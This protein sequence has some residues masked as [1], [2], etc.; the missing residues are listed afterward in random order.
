MYIRFDNIN[1]AF[2]HLVRHFHRA[3]TYGNPKDGLN[4]IYNNVPMVKTT[5][6]N[7]PVL[8]IQEP[9]LITYRNPLQRVLLNP[10]RDANPMLC[11]YEAMWMLAGRND[12]APLQYYCQQMKEYS[13]DGKT[14]NDAYGYRWRKAHTDF[15]HNR[16][17]VVTCYA[18]QLDILV[19]HLK[20]QPNSRRAVLRMWNVED[21]LLKIGGFGNRIRCKKCLGVG[22]INGINQGSLEPDDGVSS[23]VW[24]KCPKCNGTSWVDEPASKSVCCNLEVMFAVRICQVCKW[25]NGANGV[26]PAWWECS[27]CGAKPAHLDMTV[28]NRSNDMIWGLLNTNYTTFTFLQEYMAARLGVRVGLYHHMSNNLHCYEWNFKPQEW[29]KEYERNNHLAR[30]VYTA[31]WQPYPLVQSPTIF[32]QELPLFVEFNR[33]GEQAIEQPK[34]WQEPFFDEVAQPLL[35]AF[36][37]HKIRDYVGAGYRLNAIK[38]DDWRTAAVHWIEKRERNWKSK[39]YKEE[40]EKYHGGQEGVE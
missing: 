24:I 12:L 5:S 25:Q 17:Q 29:L 32:E 2:F 30:Q 36:H 11:L 18:D 37:F 7:G 39:K 6:R 9:V 16:P 8:Q 10:Y 21:D 26:D 14:I 22:G 27:T 28:T 33:N 31:S 23:D 34:H 3:T 4:S 40:R 38:A 19:A 20:D 35:N 15:Y 13:D 1:D